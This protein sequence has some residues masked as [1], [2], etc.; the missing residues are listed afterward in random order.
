MLRRFLGINDTHVLGK[1]CHGPA[2]AVL[3]IRTGDI[4]FGT[5]NKR[6]GEYRPSRSIHPKYWLYP[7][8]YYT[9]VVKH[10]RARSKTPMRIFV[11]CETLT[12]PTCDFFNQLADLDP[13]IYVRNG[14]S[15]TDDIHLLL[16]ASE[17]ATSRGTFQ[18][19]SSFSKTISVRHTFVVREPGSILPPP[20]EFGGFALDPV[21]IIDAQGSLPMTVSHYLSSYADQRFYLKAMSPWKNSV[22]QRH[23][24][25]SLWRI[26]SKTQMIT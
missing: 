14:S 20:D 8:S 26:D 3:H 24:V 19:V 5:F 25:G 21:R 13:N 6:S 22:Y 10:I 4:T 11:L 16:C 9:S 23:L 15:L 18:L 1:R 12:N 7:T 17:V 2:Y